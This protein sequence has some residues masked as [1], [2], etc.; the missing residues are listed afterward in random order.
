M[1]MACL[2]RRDCPLSELG[3]LPRSRQ[4]NRLRGRKMPTEILFT[5]LQL[6]VPPENCPGPQ[7]LGE[8]ATHFHAAGQQS[9]PSPAGL[10]GTAWCPTCLTLGWSTLHIVYQ[11]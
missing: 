7:G 8:R 9:R 5:A 1:A 11:I 10:L 4:R 3:Q 6:G 2:G